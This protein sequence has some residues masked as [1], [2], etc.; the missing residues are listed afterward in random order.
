MLAEAVFVHSFSSYGGVGHIVAALSLGRRLMLRGVDGSSEAVL[1]N[2]P[3]R[4]AD[5][6]GVGYGLDIELTDSE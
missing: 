4:F 2:T 5:G 1:N 6:E 3:F